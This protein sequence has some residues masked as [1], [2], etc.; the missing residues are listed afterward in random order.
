MRD[1]KKPIYPEDIKQMNFKELNNLSQD[2]RQFLIEN[3][4]K[5]GGHLSSNLGIVELTIALH[6][7]Y[8]SPKDKFI[9]DVGHQAY[10]HK[11]LTGRGPY[12]N[13]L[14]QKDGLSGFIKYE[15]SE[16]DV[17]EAG[18]S[19]TSLSAAAGFLEAKTIDDSIGEVIAIIGDGA[20]QNGLSF[21]AL[22]FLGSKMNQKII[23]I[24]NDNDMSISK[25]VGSL[26]KVFNKI[27]IR[28]PYKL[29]KKITPNFIHKIT[30]N[31]K[32]SIR[33]FIYGPNIFHSFGF[34]YFGPIDGHNIEELTQYLRYAKDSPHSTIIHVKTIKG[35]GY[36]YAE[37]DE[38]GLW[39][40]VSPF[41]VSTGNSHNLSPNGITSWSQ[42]I[43]EIVKIFAQKDN[44]I[45][46]LCPAMISG[47]GWLE[48]QEKLPKQII[49]VGIA[50]EHSVV[51]AAAMAR[52]KMIP[53]IS[54]YSTFLQRSYD[55]IN[56]DV[57]RNN[58]H[59]VFLIDR[60]GIVGGDG[61][62]H[63]GIFDISFLSHMPNMVITMP[64]DL[65]EAYALIYFAIYKHNGPIA[66][67]YPR[68]N[69]KTVKNYYHEEITLG[70]W[71]L[72]CN[73]KKVNIVSYGPVINDF[74]SKIIDEDLEIGLINARFI[75]PINLEMLRLLNNRT[76]FV[77]EEVIK[78]G[79][80]GSLILEAINKHNL[81]I[82]LH[83]IAV[84][85]R[86]IPQ[87]SISELKKEI[88]L[89]IDSVFEI[90]KRYVGE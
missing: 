26:S 20:F 31:L 49:D 86:Y 60:A 74:K 19:S 9:F 40:G 23:I 27:R 8:N 35:K 57:C 6:Y 28:R 82:N 66:I 42:G 12:F 13:T 39:H 65:E 62:T 84:E 56:H 59:V 30:Q 48:F 52:N 87:G 11:I 81:H 88:G 78:S 2:I 38:L 41:D 61:D 25:N 15:E 71:E 7:V 10:I 21:S 83:I 22:N 75:N 5:T 89:D 24:L 17:W 64:K 3:I 73:L 44:K 79:G 77:Y 51:M 32:N 1:F 72:I 63:Q 90:I 80:L 58:N 4:S 70:S 68:T 16:H 69:I 85:D 76:L 50:E 18:H 45:T 43:S 36:P 54:I 47:S 37:E 67:R 34:K 29:L 53:I 55:Q 33:S 46:V 14:R